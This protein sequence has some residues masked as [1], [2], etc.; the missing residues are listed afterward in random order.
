MGEYEMRKLALFAFVLSVSLLNSGLAS[1]NF[2]VKDGGF[3]DTLYQSSCCSGV[4][5]HNS[6]VCA[7][8]ADYGT[9]WA[10]CSQICGTQ[11]TSQG[12]IPD[13]GVDDTLYSTD[14]CSGRAVTGS[15]T[16]LNPA[17]YGTTWASCVQVCAGANDLDSFKSVR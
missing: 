8:P 17:D 5:V 13:G 9:T 15:T 4:A 11:P 3:D 16:C 7:N 12:C 6:T 2:C 1:A 10:S 14:C